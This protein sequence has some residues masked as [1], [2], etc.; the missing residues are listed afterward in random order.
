MGQSRGQDSTQEYEY[1]EQKQTLMIKHLWFCAT[2]EDAYYTT[3]L[4]LNIDYRFDSMY[5][6]YF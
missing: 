6:C 4:K 3:L 1:N 2:T 5:K